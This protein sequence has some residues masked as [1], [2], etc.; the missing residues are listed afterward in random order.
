MLAA[1]PPLPLDVSFAILPFLQTLADKDP[2]LTAE[3][4]PFR[5]PGRFAVKTF[6]RFLFRAQSNPP[7]E[8]WS[9]LLQSRPPSIFRPPIASLKVIR[10]SGELPAGHAQAFDTSLRPDGPCSIQPAPP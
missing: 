2:P 4:P 1:G 9:L 5:P 3:T 7:L 6:S 8:S 10:P